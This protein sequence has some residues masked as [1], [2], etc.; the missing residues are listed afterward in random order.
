M[1][2]WSRGGDQAF[3]CTFSF[4]LC[5]TVAQTGHQLL[6]VCQVSPTPHPY[7]SQD[8]PYFSTV[9]PHSKE[10]LSIS[11]NEAM[12]V[13]LTSVSLLF[14]SANS[15]SIFHATVVLCRAGAKPAEEGWPPSRHSRWLGGT[16]CQSYS[17]AARKPSC[18]QPEV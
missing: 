4:L 9:L 11:F 7:F 1:I 15:F 3:S 17:E 16:A 12:E 13:H 14:P 2:T 6:A 5:Q 18:P 10:T 8:R